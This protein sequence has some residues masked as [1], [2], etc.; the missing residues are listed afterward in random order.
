MNTQ[1]RPLNVKTLN[2]NLF[3]L[4]D[5]K[6]MLF[7][8]GSKTAFNTMTASW[9]GFGILWNKPV[10]IGFVRPQRHTFGFANESDMFTLSFFSDQ[11][12]GALEYCGAHSGRE[13]DKVAKT[14]LTPVFTERGSIY[15]SQ[16]NLVFECRKLYFD[17][18]RPDSF[19]D[20]NLIKN[21]YPKGDFHR[22]YV[23]EIINCFASD[24]F[25]AEKG[26][27][28]ERTTDEIETDF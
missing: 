21:I 18:L 13:V 24:S 12:K 4:L 14:G 1:L 2:A 6:W 20:K 26:I 3:H 5:D 28:F 22:F 25:M 11:H 23:G 15:F 16:A 27:N 7:T 9:G 8:A 10:G 17:D 19:I